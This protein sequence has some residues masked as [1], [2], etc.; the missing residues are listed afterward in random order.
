MP[1]WFHLISTLF[2][3]RREEASLAG[4]EDNSSNPTPSPKGWDEGSDDLA[5]SCNRATPV[6]RA[7]I[8]PLRL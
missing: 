4:R 1:P 3:A 2:L 7:G 6:S 8:Q 5:C